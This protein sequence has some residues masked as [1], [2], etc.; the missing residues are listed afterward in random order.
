[1]QLH[2]KFKRRKKQK[3]RS[4]FNRVR[5][6]GNKLR[7]HKSNK[8]LRSHNNASESKIYFRRSDYPFYSRK[9]PFR[10]SQRR[11]DNY[12]Y[13]DYDYAL[14]IK[15]SSRNYYY[16]DIYDY[17]DEYN[18]RTYFT[19]KRGYGGHHHKPSSY[20]LLPLLSILGLIGL[21]LNLGLGKIKTEKLIFL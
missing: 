21:L 16:D 13:I 4:K 9:R 19:F 12:E 3:T 20:N 18:R 11:Y 6:Q 1:M 10:P 7:N 2:R 5:L 15:F 17:D 14:P 8:K